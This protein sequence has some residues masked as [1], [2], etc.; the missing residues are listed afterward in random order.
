MESGQTPE[1]AQSRC[2]KRSEGTLGITWGFE[3][4]RDAGKLGAWS[5]SPEILFCLAEGQGSVKKRCVAN[6]T[7]FKESRLKHDGWPSQRCVHARQGRKRA[8]FSAFEATNMNTIGTSHSKTNLLKEISA[9]TRVPSSMIF[10]LG[11]C[12]RGH[13]HNKNSSERH[14]RLHRRRHH[15]WQVTH[16]MLFSSHVEA[17]HGF[18]AFITMYVYYFCSPFK[19][20]SSPVFQ[21][22]RDAPEEMYPFGQ[23][24][25]PVQSPSSS[26]LRVFLSLQASGLT[27]L[28]CSVHPFLVRNPEGRW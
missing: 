13:F 16:S 14:L 3:K 22:D 7:G 19:R 5:S 28:C 2:K 23:F 25:R 4:P 9:I 21:T 27:V 20:Y 17:V 8:V 12:E 10:Y 18:V 6:R 1:G 26:S 15:S 24:F 11:Q